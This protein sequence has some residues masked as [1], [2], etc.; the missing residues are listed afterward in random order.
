MAR[1]VT[2]RGSLLWVRLLAVAACNRT[3]GE[4]HTQ[5][6]ADEILIGAVTSLTGSEA[7]YGASA[8]NGYAMAQEQINRS[9]GIYGKK[10]RI[11][12]ADDAGKT[13]EALQ[14]T[15]RLVETEHVVAI[16]GADSSSHS[17]AMATFAQ[18]KRVPMITPSATNPRVTEVGDYIFRI[19]FIDP[20]QGGVMARF[21]RG[22]L[23]A[24]RVA[25]LKDVKNE[26]SVGLA[27]F[28]KEKFIALGGVVVAEPTYS[29]TDKDFSAQLE[30][31]RQAKPDLI[32]VPGYYTD[33]GLIIRQARAMKVPGIFAGGDGWDAQPIFEIGGKALEG[34]YFTNHYSPEGTDPKLKAFVKE[35]EAKYH[36]VPDSGVALA[37]DAAMI[38][39][40][41]MKR[42]KSLD[43]HDLRD[44]IA[45]TKNFPGVTGMI[46]IDAK[47]NAQKPAVILKI[48]GGKTKYLKTVAP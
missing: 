5:G 23:K 15:T 20:F 4:N 19:C 17:M 32:Y 24:K 12:V 34:S 7:N 28:F 25:I 48:E 22:D 43:N 18:G 21:A 33:A 47:R 44:A 39:A 2:R 30:L 27:D 40:E 45:Q 42:A 3:G 13:D 11:E 16:L 29:D 36:A 14:V 10:V 38:L 6:T 35:Y 31:I 46:T 9:G 26:Y 1:M 41:A 8:R 37:Y